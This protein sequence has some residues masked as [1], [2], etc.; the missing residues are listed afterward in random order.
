MLQLNKKS[1]YS[2]DF[3][4]LVLD[5]AVLPLLFNNYLNNINFKSLLSLSHMQSKSNEGLKLLDTP[6]LL[7]DKTN[8]I[9]T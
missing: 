5:N 3:D 4:K 1:I 2:S 6:R 9:N 7:T 8:S